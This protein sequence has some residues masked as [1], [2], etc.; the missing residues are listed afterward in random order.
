[1]GYIQKPQR[2]WWR[3]AL[4]QVHLWVGIILGL[5]IIVIGLT[6]SIL[7]FKDELAALS[8]PG[9]RSAQQVDQSRWAN[10]A[11]VVENARAAHPRHKF[12]SAYV[13]T[14]FS[15]TFLTYM[16][17]PNQQWLYVFA[18]PADGHIVG[19]SDLKSSWLFWVA[20]LHFRLLAGDTGWILNGTG[21]AFLVLLSITGIL[22]WW[23]GIKTWP[24]ALKVGFKRGWKRIN[25][26]LHSAIGFW[27]LAIVFM[28]ALSG[29]Y[30]V[31]PKQFEAV[32]NRFSSVASA[33]EPEIVVPPKMEGQSA[34]LRVLLSQAQSASPDA[35]L[36]GL[37]IPEG[38]KHP[39][40][41]FMAR[42]GHQDFSQMDRIYFD[43]SSGKQ[44]GIWHAGVNP[45]LGAK[46]VYWLGPLH[47]GVYW[48]S[49]IKILWA[50]LGLSLPTLTVTGAL[51][52]W[53][54]SLSKYWVKLKTS[55][56][57]PNSQEVLPEEMRRAS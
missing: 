37:Y 56:R 18:D 11:T 41:V 22:L 51:M 27:T 57:K 45:T 35:K 24:R 13:P 4:F 42:N 46:F 17:G 31:W 38:A 3:R 8:Y 16:E 14:V 20:E 54:R 47:F 29:V 34:N 48:G 49:G 32:V 12:V 6:G 43:P 7:V 50:F 23:P 53:N 39:I 19:D 30:F 25:F 9:M 40:T 44:L 5:Y 26:D 36:S 28:W 55:S 10:L 15:N 52:Y 21:A 1:M 2:V 33:I